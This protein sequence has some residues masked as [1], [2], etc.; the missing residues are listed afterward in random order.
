LSSRRTRAKE[1][2]WLP[3]PERVE[4]LSV[5]SDISTD[6]S[7]E[8]QEAMEQTA[9]VIADVLGD[10][11]AID[12]LTD[13]RRWMVPVAVHHPEPAP[14]AHFQSIL[15]TRF[16]VDEGFTATTLDS[17]QSILIPRVTPVEMRAMQPAI[18]PVCEALG[19]RGFIVV[20]I[21]VGKTTAVIWQV[22]TRTEPVLQDDDRRFLE[23]VGDRLA[24]IIENWR[25]SS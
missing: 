1:R 11:F 14:L 4:I 2:A 15:G 10:G 22:R 17:G 6:E 5:L 16:P 3:T 12:L 20:P 25:L 18:A 23:E 9:V 13:D 8:H 21:G 7:V 24:V 19:M